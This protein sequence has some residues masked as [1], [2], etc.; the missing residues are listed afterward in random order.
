LHSK[1]YDIGAYIRMCYLVESGI[2]PEVMRKFH[3]G[4]ILLR[5]ECFFRREIH[6]GDKV[7]V[8]LELS[9]SRRDASRWS[10][11]HH[12]YKNDHKLC[13]TINVDGAWLDTQKRKLAPLPEEIASPFFAMPRI[14][15]FE[16]D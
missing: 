1:Y 4:P 2:T 10:I 5:E 8:D 14:E 7:Y 11:Q 16:W 13:A 3:V 12:L 6:F 9:K 15:G